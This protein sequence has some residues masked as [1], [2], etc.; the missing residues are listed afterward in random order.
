MFLKTTETKGAQFSGLQTFFR[1]VFKSN[2][3]ANATMKCLQ[4]HYGTKENAKAKILSVVKML[5]IYE[6]NLVR[7]G[8]DKSKSNNFMRK[9][10]KEMSV[11][12]LE[13]DQLRNHF[14]ISD[15]RG[16]LISVSYDI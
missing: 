4:K 1:I 16:L 5:S 3:K 7:L 10:E 6:Y 12:G 14:M 8:L 15:L 11:F 13:A 2:L 9:F